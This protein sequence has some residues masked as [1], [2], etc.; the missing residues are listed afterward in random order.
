[1]ETNLLIVHCIIVGVI[2]LIIGILIERIVLQYKD[3]KL[4]NKNET[5]KTRL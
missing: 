2:G 5:Q 3:R 1:M 4:I